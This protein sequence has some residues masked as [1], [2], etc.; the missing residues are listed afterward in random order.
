LQIGIIGGTGL[1]DPDILEQRKE[2]VITTPYGDPSDVL[3]E[4][5][6]N[7]VNCVILARHGRKHSVMPTNVNYRANIWALRHVGCTHILGSTACGSLR[8]NI[9]PGDLVVANDFIDRTTKRNQTFYDGDTNSPQGVCHIPMFPAFNERIRQILL[10]SANELGISV[11]DIGCIVTIEGPRYSSHSE[12]NMYRQWGGD[13]IN[14]TTCPEVVLAKEAG[15]LYGVVAIATDY[16][17]WRTDHESVSTQ[18]VLNTFTKNIDKLKKIL[19]KAVGTIAKE[20]WT[21]TLVA[22]K[23]SIINNT[24]TLKV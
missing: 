15:L 11:H 12:S 8:E 24:M 7:G 20:D 17:C 22:A 3:I 14:M 6:I 1:N 10:S 19:V 2:T 9:K 13:L 16:D 18:E 21:D 23:Q 4:G 5:Q